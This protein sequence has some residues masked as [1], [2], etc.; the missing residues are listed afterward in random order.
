MKI[1]ESKFPN[2]MK[3]KIYLGQKVRTIAFI[4]LFFELGKDER[5]IPFS[6]NS[7][8]IVAWLTRIEMLVKLFRLTTACAIFS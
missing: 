8:T 1:I 3:Q 6:K 4:E 2:V 7:C 5:S